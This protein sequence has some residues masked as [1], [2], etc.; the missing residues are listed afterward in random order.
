LHLAQVAPANFH[1]PILDQLQPAELPLGDP[2]EPGPLW[3]VRF[4][5]P[6]KGGL[7]CQETLE[8]APRDTDHATVLADLDPEPLVTW[9]SLMAP[10]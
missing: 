7:L 4:D 6:L 1:V 10:F 3:V 8:H 5:A 2:L 9:L